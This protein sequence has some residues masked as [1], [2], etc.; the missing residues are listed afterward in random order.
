MTLT[1]H[2]QNSCRD[3]VTSLTIVRRVGQAGDIGRVLT[4]RDI[5]ENKDITQT[6]PIAVLMPTI[7]TYL[8]DLMIVW[9]VETTTI[10]TTINTTTIRLR[11]EIMDQDNRLTATITTI[12]SASIPITLIVT[13][14][15]GTTG[16]TAITSTRTE[17]GTFEGF[18][19]ISNTYLTI[20][21]CT[22]AFYFLND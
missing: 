19:H 12:R 22:Y 4:R 8:N 3:N 14:I 10:T 5:E 16:L 21:H 13:V 9:T 11:I 2:L 1:S 17:E 7:M 15:H 18:I 20:W 6:L